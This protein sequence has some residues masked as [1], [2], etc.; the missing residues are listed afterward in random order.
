MFVLDPLLSHSVG[1]APMGRSSN[2]SHPTE[3]GGWHYESDPTGT[4]NARKSPQRPVLSLKQAHRGYPRNELPPVWRTP[5]M[6]RR[7]PSLGR[8]STCLEPIHRSSGSGPSSWPGCGEKPVAKIADDLGIADIVPAQ[9]DEAGRHRR[10]PTRRARA[11]TSGPSW[12]GCAGSCARR[13][14]RSRSSSVRPP[15]SPRRHARAQND[16]HL[17][18]PGLHGPA[19]VGLL[20]GHEGVDLGLLCLAGQPGHRQGPRRRVSRPTRSSTSGA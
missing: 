7:E 12:C 14:W 5:N 3:V 2:E 15:T 19:R 17:H 13:R 8:M 10:R 20:S 4:L 18:R 11:P 6:R 1:E 16:L 9:L